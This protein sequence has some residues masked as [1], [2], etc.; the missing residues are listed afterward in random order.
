MSDKIFQIAQAVC[1]VCDKKI[2]CRIDDGK[3]F[4]AKVDKEGFI[5]L[6]RGG[7]PVTCLPGGPHDLTIYMVTYDMTDGKPGKVTR[8]RFEDG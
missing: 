6:D 3:P 5:C 1:E 8:E 7:Q 4:P 2:M